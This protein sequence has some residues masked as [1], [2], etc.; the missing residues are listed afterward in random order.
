[1]TTPSWPSDK[2]FA[3]TSGAKETLPVLAQRS[4]VDAG[5]PR[6]RRM[7]VATPKQYVVQY[8]MTG[9]EW[10]WLV[11]FFTNVTAGGA[12]WFD[13]WNPFFAATWTARFRADQPPSRVPFA[14]DWTVTV[15]IEALP[16]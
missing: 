4:T 15:N 12:L 10:A 13:W 3:L 9:A 14:P 6:Q 11:D 5:D 2:G 7:S 1:M 16:K 8:I